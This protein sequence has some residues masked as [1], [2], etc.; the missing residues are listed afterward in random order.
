MGAAILVLQ[1][2]R[3][4]G[5]DSK[6]SYDGGYEPTGTTGEVAFHVT[7]AVPPGVDLVQGV[8]SGHQGFSFD[9]R[10]IVDLRNPSPISIRTPIH[11]LGD[12]RVT[13]K[14]SRLR[15]LPN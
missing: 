7:A 6:V 11:G 15:G 8:N 13:A 4:F 1:Q 5:T 2:G 12:V 14:I 9:I 3:V 10:A